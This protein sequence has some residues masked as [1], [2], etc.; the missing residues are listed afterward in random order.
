MTT[1]NGTRALISAREGEEVFIGSF[2]NLSALAQR[3]LERA[4]D[5]FVACAGEKDLFCL[6]DTVCGG[7]IIDRLEKTG[8]PI[9]KSDAAMTAKLTYEHCAE[10]I[11]AMLS[12]CEWGQH[13]EKIGLGKDVRVCARIDSSQ[14]VPVYREGRIVVER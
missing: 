2:L 5:V 9:L 8:A 14:L 7:A 13:L 4:R 10:N 12:D 1:T 3:L 6:E 11:Y